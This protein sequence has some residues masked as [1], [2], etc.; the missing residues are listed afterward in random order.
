MV[1]SWLKM[2]RN[3][4]IGSDLVKWG[5]GTVKMGGNQLLAHLLVQ[6]LKY[7]LVETCPWLDRNVLEMTH[8]SRSF[9]V[10]HD[11]THDLCLHAHSLLISSPSSSTFSSCVSIYFVH[12]FTLIPTGRPPWCDNACLCSISASFSC[13]HRSLEFAL[14][15]EPG[16]EHSQ[17]S[18]WGG[19]AVRAETASL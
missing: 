11:R 12:Y 3:L 18:S 1:E 19:S 9:H 10:L 4:R 5:G 2:E 14:E 16:I 6:L 8:L 15:M 13:L 17:V 7:L